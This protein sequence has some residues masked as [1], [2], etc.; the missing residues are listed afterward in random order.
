MSGSMESFL[1]AWRIQ[2]KLL[3]L[4]FA[5]LAGFYSSF[6]QSDSAV[7]LPDVGQ[8]RHTIST[9][10]PRPSDFSIRDS[11]WFSLSTTRKPLDRSAGHRN[12]T[13]SQRWRFGMWH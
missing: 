11:H 1:N 8:H 10:N 7:L 5:F 4:A 6:A 9:K 3:A 2:V 13:R 12:W